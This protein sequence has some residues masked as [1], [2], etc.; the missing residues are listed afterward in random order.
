MKTEAR[1]CMG[2][3]ECIEFFEMLPDIIPKML[4]TLNFV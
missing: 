4:K 2:G 1:Q 3:L